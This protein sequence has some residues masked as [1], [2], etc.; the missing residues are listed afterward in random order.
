MRILWVGAHPDDELFIA[1]WLGAMRKQHDAR[2]DFVVA[3]HG[4]RGDCLRPEGCEPDMAT[5]R[6]SE[7]RAAAAIFGGEVAYGGCR[8]LSAKTAKGVL[9]EWSRDAGGDEALRK[10]FHELIAR[11]T[12]DHLLTFDPSHESD[13]HSDHR[14]I[15]LLVDSLG[16]TVPI[17][18]A[19]SELTW[20]A[21]LQVT[22]AV[23]DAVAFDAGPWWDYLVRDISCHRSQ[24]DA[25]SVEMFTSAAEEQRRVWMRSKA[26]V[27]SA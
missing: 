13:H 1:P 23:P 10:R 17:T 22:P 7:M 3:T 5:V 18:Y 12:P 8:D 27:A 2:I 6:D 15:A 26:N 20:R 16:L 21:P 9:A 24:F 11:F 14:A 25:R 4:E 19:E